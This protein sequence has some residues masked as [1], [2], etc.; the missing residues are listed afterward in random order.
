MTD[1]TLTPS[2]L[3][4]VLAEFIKQRIPLVIEGDPGIGKTS[5]VQQVCAEELGGIECRSWMRGSQMD[6]VYLKGMPL[7]PVNG[8]D[9]VRWAVPD[10]FPTDP[11]SKGVLF[12]DE[13]GQSPD[14]VQAAMMQWIL[15]NRSG[16][17]Q[18]P[19]GWSQIAATNLE[20]N[21][22]GVHKMLAALSLR[23]TWVRMVPDVSD[24]CKR[25][26]ADGTVSAE[27]VAFI[28]FRPDLLHQFDPKQH[29]SPNP[30]SWERVS[31]IVDMHLPPAAEMAT[32]AG[33][34]SEGPMIELIAFL[35]ICHSLPNLDQV[36][37]NP[38]TAPVPEK[39]DA[40]FAIA[41][42]IARR[43]TTRNIGAVLQYAER[44][45]EEMSVYVYRDATARDVSLCNTAA[46]TTFAVDHQEIIA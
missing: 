45:G 10:F 7:P 32:I 30:R 15:E 46:A 22:S 28:R 37:L 21:R 42:G 1:Y 36:L 38:M 6:P 35:E 3:R 29:S 31:R 14:S 41:G 26:L 16:M 25:M 12:W 24:W 43:A 23:F 18:L 39:I 19:C 17:R 4:P 13:I 5:V 9:T 34:V 44:L 8:H 11:N 40:R 27:I 20:S 2:Q 33:T